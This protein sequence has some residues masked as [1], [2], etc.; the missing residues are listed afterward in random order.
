VSEAAMHEIHPTGEFDTYARDAVSAMLRARSIAVIGASDKP[1][2]FGRN[3]I[4][5]LLE[6]GFSCRFVFHGETGGSGA[7]RVPFM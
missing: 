3:V 4:T 7:G 6:T 2:T 1:E 5:Q